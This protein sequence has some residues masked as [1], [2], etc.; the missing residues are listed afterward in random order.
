[1][2]AEE[3]QGGTAINAGLWWNP[4]PTDWDFN[5][6]TGWKATDMASASAR[7]FARIPGTDT[8]SMDDERY[9]TE[10]FDVLSSGLADAG[11]ESVK[12]NEV[13]E[14]K[15]HTFTHTPYMFANG[16]R[17]GP[18]A[19]YLE[20]A[21]AR[22]NFD[23]WVNTTVKRVIR[24]G[25][26]ITGVEVE[27]YADGGYAGIVN[28]TA[29]TGRVI[30]SAGAFGSSKILFRSG[31]GPADQLEIV[32]NST[33]GSTMIESTEWINLPVG[34]NLDDHTNTDLVI[35]HPNVTFYDF[36]A[37]WSAPIE[38][39]KN[40]YLNNRTG[41]LAQSAPNIGPI[42]FEEIEGA[43]GIVRQMQYTSRV[44]GSDGHESGKTMTISQY[45]G[46]G[47]KSRGRT[48][49]DKNLN[50][51]VS[52]VPYLQDAEDLA[53]V[54]QSIKNIQAALSNVQDL[55]FLSPGSNVS[56]EDYVASKDIDTSRSAN[57]WVGTAKMG[58]DDGRTESGTAVVDTNCKVYGTDNLFVVDASIFPGMVTTNPS[59]LIVTVAEKASEVILA[60]SD[61]NKSVAKNPISMA[62]VAPDLDTEMAPSG[63]NFTPPA[64]TFAP[65]VTLP[66]SQPSASDPAR[67]ASGGAGGKMYDQCGGSSSWTGP[68]SCT[69]GTCTVMNDFYAQCL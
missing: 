38:A 65:S 37:A 49:L 36:Y 44:E 6:P 69:E 25:G 18:M 46:R 61:T 21:L 50:M 53:A 55:V 41:I 27:P 43:D 40:S 29:A 28:V 35:S 4:N 58:T 63:T 20:S 56:V 22:E 3:F 48:T 62:A 45:L 24:S 59:A 66:T 60:L 64:T 26:L 7:V 57:H 68:T 30:L 19:T 8:P 23:L 47:S 15:N 16:E 31:I 32:Q 10:G 39:D 9:Y 33:D 13:P 17:G 11:W 67:S 54:I 52:T 14:K 42:M 5:F 12:A 1:M 2:N 34:K 51:V